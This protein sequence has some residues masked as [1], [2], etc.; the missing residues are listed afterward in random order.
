MFA[1]QNQGRPAARYLTAAGPRHRAARLW[2]LLLIALA[3]AVPAGVAALPQPALGAVAAPGITFTKL[4]LLNG[5]GTYPGS[6]SPAVADISGIVYFQGAISTSNSNT[7]DVA[8]V[9]PPAFRPAKFVNVPV[10]MCNSTEGEL[11]IAPT[12]ETQV[13]SNGANSNATCFTSLDGASFALSTASFT[14]LKLRPGW[15]E[16]DNFYRKAAVRLTGGI[17]HLE[18][19]IKTAGTKQMAFTLPAKFRPARNVNVLINVCTGSIGRLHITP[20]GVVTVRSGVGFW[21]VKCGTSLDG[22]TFALS[23]KSFTSLTL[24]NGWMNAPSGTAKAAVR[25]IAGVVRFSG[26]IWH[27]TLAEPFIL[28]KG[29]R[30]STDV[31]IPVDLCNGDT[32]RL[33]IQ[34]NG[35]VAVEAEHNFA[36]AQCLTSLDG[37]WFTR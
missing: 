25:I 22:A 17:V 27:G 33:D 16:F 29:F 8:F 30:P 32:G 6:A 36:Q 12:G 13:I 11:D 35:T 1:R 9:L 20:K 10:D 19:E 4:T 34:P 5:W 28:P 37:A 2:W 15:T 24:K 18:G 3:A 23:P 21:A 7:N 26:A 14:V 31:F